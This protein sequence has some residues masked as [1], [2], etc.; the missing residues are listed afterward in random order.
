MNE[1]VNGE[2]RYDVV[3]V[4]GGPAGLAAA[5]TLG[6][7][8][9]TVLVVDDGRPRN[10]PAAGVHNYLGREGTPPEELLAD[11]R[12]EAA[13]YG[14]EFRTGTVT[15]AYR[16]GTGFRV[17]LADGGEVPARR[18]LVT[19]GLTDELPDV[20]GMAQRWGRDVLHCPYCHGWEVR[21]RPIGVLATGPAGVHQ[22]ML[23]RQWSPDVTLF[24]HA[25]PG[26]DD[27]ARERLTARGIVIVEEE[28]AALEVTGDRLTGVR[29]AGG[30]V[31]PVAA[32]VAPPQTVARAGFLA[33]LGVRTDE[34]S[35]AGSVMG[36]HVPAEPTGATSVPGVW[37]AGNVTSPSDTV[38]AS[39]AAGVRTA[40]V[41]NMDLVNEDTDR[42]VAAHRSAFSAEL[43]A[44]AAATVAADTR[45]GL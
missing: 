41:L 39:A 9:R 21:D 24:V 13:G 37:V 19:T 4:G 44:E 26:P 34:L 40:G 11:G 10:A 45:H 15:T 16:D 8:R 28:V 14:G 17:V 20:P 3:V 31:V 25:G 5:V 30:R 1:Q 18:L 6:R 43:E 33:D 36:V 23:W 32:V 35:M 7:A 22:A 38:I 27:A 2:R 29:L 42:A 12:R